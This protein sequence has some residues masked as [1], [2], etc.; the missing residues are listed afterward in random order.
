MLLIYTVTS[1]QFKRV[2]VCNKLQISAHF[3]S[4]GATCFCKPKGFFEI[5]SKCLGTFVSPSDNFWTS[6]S[7]W[8]SLENCQ[9]HC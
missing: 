9:K 7:G 3:C 2:W 6:E 4:L 5:F 1:N 8:R